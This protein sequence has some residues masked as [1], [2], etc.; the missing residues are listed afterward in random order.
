MKD[1]NNFNWTMEDIAHQYKI[2]NPDWSWSECWSKARVIYRELKNLNNELWQ[3]NKQ[4]FRMNTPF[5]F[6][7]N[8]DD[9]FSSKYT[10]HS[11]E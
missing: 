2:E 6:F 10:S 8:K 5:S 7:D 11:G 4:F 9:E 3:N 1:K